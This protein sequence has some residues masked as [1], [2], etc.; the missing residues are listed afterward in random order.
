MTSIVLNGRE[1][2]YNGGSILDAIEDDCDI[3]FNCRV[4][5]CKMCRIVVKEGE[6]KKSNPE[7]YVLAC[8]SRPVTSVVEIEVE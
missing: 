3:Q 5:I 1:Y 2:E 4:G 8:C 6:V 7:D